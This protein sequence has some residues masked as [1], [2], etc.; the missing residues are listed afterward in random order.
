M[1]PR[2]PDVLGTNLDTST[3]NLK[4][5]RVKAL[6]IRQPHASLVAIGV[7]TIETRKWSINW[8]GKLA[9]HSAMHK[10]R[11][12]D[13][14]LPLGVVLAV[15]DLVGCVPI[16]ELNEHD[17]FGIGDAEG[18]GHFGWLLANVEPLTEPVRATGKL[19]I[20][21]WADVR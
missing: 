11:G 16:E 9:I 6:T 15:C 19:G 2:V 17:G 5:R 1:H 3:D 14:S 20:W 7:K 21:D 12:W 13:E 8:R 10:P 18:P 4:G